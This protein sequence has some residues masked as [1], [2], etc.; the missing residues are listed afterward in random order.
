MW[1]DRLVS[2]SAQAKVAFGSD[3]IGGGR[4]ALADIDN[5]SPHRRLPAACTSG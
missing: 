1:A 3:L 2:A 5:P 4:R